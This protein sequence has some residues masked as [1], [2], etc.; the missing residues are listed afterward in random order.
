MLSFILEWGMATSGSNARVALRMR[1]SISEI[2]SVIILPTG[3]CHPGNQ[4]VQRRLAKRQARAAKFAQVAVAPAGHRT[5]VDHARRAGV[6][7]QLAQPGIVVLGLE[8]GAQSGEFLDR[9]GLPL[10][11]LNPGCFCHKISAR[12]A[13]PLS[14]LSPPSLRRRACP[15]S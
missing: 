5:A 12:L 13:A 4:S 3:L 14:L 8:F 9:G 15:S 11:P 10:V 2:V 1:V 7:G 6:A